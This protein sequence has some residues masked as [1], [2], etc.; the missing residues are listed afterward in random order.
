MSRRPEPSQRPPAVWLHGDAEVLGGARL[1]LTTADLASAGSLVLPAGALNASRHEALLKCEAAA[2]PGRRCPRAITL[3]L[4]LP[5][6]LNLTLT[7][8]LTLTLILTLTLTLT[9]TPTPTLT[10]TPTLN[11]NQGDRCKAAMAV[12]VFP[13]RTAGCPPSS[14]EKGG[15]LGLRVS[16]LTAAKCPG[17]PRTVASGAC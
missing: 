5:L 4:T 3:T 10:L 13:S 12:T 6:I 8:D 2:V 17:K 16:F 15:G 9:P 11:S 14:L 7:L 1:R